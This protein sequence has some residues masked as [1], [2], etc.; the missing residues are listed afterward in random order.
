MRVW[1]AMVVL[2][3]SL[4]VGCM[5]ELKWGS[6]GSVGDTR[7][8][9]GA[10]PRGAPG[11]PGMRCLF[12]QTCNTAYGACGGE[13]RCVDARCVA[14]TPTCDDGIACTLDSCTE[15]VAGEMHCVNAPIDRDGDWH[16][17]I[18]CLDLLGQPLGDD[19]DDN[20]PYRFPGRAEVCDSMGHDEDCDAT[21]IGTYLD[22]DAGTG[23]HA[24]WDDD[25]AGVPCPWGA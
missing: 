5:G 19:C 9:M 8:A 18:A 24:D 14:V 15:L 21:T 1:L 11:P 22:D 16:G 25:D 6:E 10:G 2:Y 23:H 7:P 4:S 3:S 17:D 13:W 20:D 12:S